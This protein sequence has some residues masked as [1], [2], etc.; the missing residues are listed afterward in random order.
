[1]YCTCSVFPQFR[2][3]AIYFVHNPV[4]PALKRGQHLFIAGTFMLSLFTC[5][6]KFLGKVCTSDASQGASGFHSLGKNYYLTQTMDKS[7]TCSHAV[8]RMNHKFF[9]GHIPV[10][11]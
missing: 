2:C 5:M 10:Y 6:N 7:M 8:A 11:L 1:M 4:D 3:L 9:V